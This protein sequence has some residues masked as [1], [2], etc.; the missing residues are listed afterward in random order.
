M[1]TIGLQVRLNQKYDKQLTRRMSTPNILTRAVSVPSHL[2]LF[3]RLVLSNPANPSD[4]G[5]GGR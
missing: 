3:F 4:F 2:R 1:L 5:I